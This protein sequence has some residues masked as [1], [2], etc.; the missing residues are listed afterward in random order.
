MDENW[1]KLASDWQT[2]EAP[3]IDLEALRR[4]TTRQG[5]YL[6][7]ML[8][9]ELVFSL[10]VVGICAVIALHPSSDRFEALLFGA[11][12][13][14]LVV[15]QSAMVWLRRRG[16]RESGLDALALVETGLRRGRGALLYWRLGMWTGLALWLAIY[17]FYI[18]GLHY[19][20][21]GVRLEGLAGGLMIN[22][23]VFPVIGL[24]GWWRSRE[25]RTR[26]A[27]LHALREQLRA[28]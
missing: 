25:T 11:M 13:L 10:L 2:Q 8:G 18:A 21:E 15:Y 5:R 17:A 6:K 26:M 3:G 27:R 14:F 12:G 28:P 1:K 22:L 7:L 16:L 23:V 24:Y 9:L 4:E 19:E 20:W